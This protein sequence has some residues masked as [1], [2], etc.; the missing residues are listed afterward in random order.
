MTY[1]LR[2]IQMTRIHDDQLHDYDFEVLR[3]DQGDGGWSIHWKHDEPD[4]NGLRPVL[5]SGPS[6]FDAERGDWARPTHEDF[7]DAIEVLLKAKQ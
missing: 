3:S 4:E 2:R 5:L 1:G 7:A 6:S